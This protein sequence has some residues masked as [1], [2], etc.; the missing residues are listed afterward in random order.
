GE[1]MRAVRE[2]QPP[3]AALRMAGR[4]QRKAGLRGTRTGPAGT[5]A[6]RDAQARER[7]GAPARP[8]QDRAQRLL[9]HGLEHPREDELRI[10]GLHP[11]EVPDRAVASMEVR[12]VTGTGVS[13]AISSN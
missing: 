13:P 5:R 9:E 7:P 1:D 6:G 11:G 8:S 3:L 10:A 2:P 4:V 12:V